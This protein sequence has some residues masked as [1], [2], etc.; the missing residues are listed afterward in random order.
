MTNEPFNINNRS[1]ELD[2][3]EAQRVQFGTIDVGIRIVY[4][5]KADEPP[6]E[7]SSDCAGFERFLRAFDHWLADCGRIVPDEDAFG[8]TLLRGR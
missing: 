1:I 5:I 3:V 4:N 6:K 2:T 8:K 7:I